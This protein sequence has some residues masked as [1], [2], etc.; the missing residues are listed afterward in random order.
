MLRAARP[1]RRW[2]RL[3]TQQKEQSQLRLPLLLLQGQRGAR[4]VV[5]DAA[6]GVGVA[7]GR[8]GEAVPVQPRLASGRQQARLAR[9]ERLEHL[10]HLEHLEQR[11]AEVEDVAEAEAVVAA[12]VEEAGDLVVAEHQ[13]KVSRQVIRGALG[14][15]W[16][17][18]VFPKYPPPQKKK[19]K[20]RKTQTRWPGKQAS[21]QACTKK[22]G[23]NMCN[24]L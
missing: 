20:E 12:A 24:R 4:S 9:L 18:C 21:L 8:E 5:A 7:A 3:K 19:K 22:E 6:E 17:Q 15:A 16:W 2:R 10:E 13:H 1:E 11:V 23:T 14:R